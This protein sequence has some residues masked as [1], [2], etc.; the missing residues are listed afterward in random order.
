MAATVTGISSMATRQILAELSRAFQNK[1]GHTVA[2]E[3]VGGVDAAKRVRAG[4]TFDIVVLADDVM[5]QLDAD[6]FLR[7][8]SRAGFAKSAMAV[9]VGAQ[10]NRPDLSNEANLQAAVLAARSIGYST[11]P[12]GTHLL[13]LL[14]R[15]GIE[16]TVSDRLVKA[17]P[18]VP[19]GTLVARGE[20]ELGFQQ[21]S[22]FLDVPGIAVAGSLP[23]EVQSTTLFACGV[24]ATASNAAGAHDL[25]R[26]LTSAEADASKRRYGM[27]PA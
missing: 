4:E 2:I 7:P 19:V 18:G 27:E 9:A 11:G 21:L 10:A 23:P 5:T 26:H 20:A 1:T 14:R 16:Q 8:G 3:S 15:W 17:S 24:C 13:G 22:E 25:I 6:G 12:S